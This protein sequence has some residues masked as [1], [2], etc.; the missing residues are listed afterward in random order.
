MTN[1]ERKFVEAHPKDV[2]TKGLKEVK[3]NNQS[4]VRTLS[5]KRMKDFTKNK[6]FFSRK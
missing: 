1:C 5:L 4:S 2:C 6:L 3:E